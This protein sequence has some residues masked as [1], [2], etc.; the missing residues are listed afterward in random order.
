MVKRGQTLFALKVPDPFFPDSARDSAATHQNLSARAASWAVPMLAGCGAASGLAWWNIR[1]L[2]DARE[3]LA[4]FYGWF[5]LAFCCYLAALW[6]IRRLQAVSLRAAGSLLA[7]V[8]IG[9]VLFRAILLPTT[10]TLSD[11]IYRYRW[12]GRLQQAGIDP[13]RYPPAAPELAALRDAQ[14]QSINFPHLRTVYPPLTQ[15]AFRVGVIL[16]NTLT[17]QKVVFVGAELITVASILVILW[18]RGL[19]LLWVVAYA[20]HPLAVLEI[21]GSGHNDALGVACLWL[22]LLAWERGRHGLAAVGWA[23]AFLAKYAT[24]ILLPWWW[25]RRVA[26][27][28]LALLCVLA[29]LPLVCCPTVVSALTQSLSTMTARFESNSSLY[30][31]LAIVVGHP[32]IARVVVTGAW[33]LWLLW[34]ARREPDPLRYLFGGL[35]AAALLSPA[36]HPWYLVWLI[37]FL[38]FWRV[39]S[40]VAFTGVVVLAYT[41]WPG[42]LAGGAWAMPVWAHVGEYAAVAVVGLWSLRR[43]W[44]RSSF[45]LA[46]KPSLSVR[47]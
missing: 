14:W 27:R 24:V 42:Y 25:C 28:W 9:A 45:R 44:W 34:W 6:L 19:S 29:A 41:V 8:A 7:V 46:T 20:W 32:G 2:G 1:L 11:D 10:P 33:G 4:S 38:C 36:V 22:G 16:G 43:W 30:M 21:A 47:S 31:V 23:S 26:R 18:R 35:G 12:D 15:L 3:R 17:A 40:V 39:P 13:Y 5:A 37:P